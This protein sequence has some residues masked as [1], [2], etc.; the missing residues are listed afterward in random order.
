MRG[1]FVAAIS[2]MVVLSGCVHSQPD[3]PAAEPISEAPPT[4][5]VQPTPAERTATPVAADTGESPTAVL[6]RS[7]APPPKEKASAAQSSKPPTARTPL[8]S[9]ASSPEELGAPAQPSVAVTTPTEPPPS[10]ALDLAELEQRLRD[11]RAIGVFT[12]LSLKNQID[13]LLDQF[14]GFYGGQIKVT[15]AELR[16][17][18]ELLLLKVLTLLQDADQELAGTIAASREAIWGILADPQKFAKI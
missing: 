13:D 3:A 5:G 10:P 2:A 14:R 12:K 11:T 9:A 17:R 16:Q 18:Y 15:L 6:P 1:M 8:E 7:P 4:A